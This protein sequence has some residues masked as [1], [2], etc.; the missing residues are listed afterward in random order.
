MDL[1][2]VRV[3]R[4]TENRSPFS[5]LKARPAAVRWWP[6]GKS[7]AFIEGLMSDEGFHGGDLFTVAADGGAVVNRT[8]D[9]KASVSSFFWQTPNQILV[10]EYVGG[11]SAI[12]ELSL[13][14]NSAK[15]IW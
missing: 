12:S 4:M 15:L 3:G 1:R 11:G 7:I 14:N 13:S 10:T 5:T 2:R 8:R 9:R 6:H